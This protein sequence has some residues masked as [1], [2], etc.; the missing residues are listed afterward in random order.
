VE[1]PRSGEEIGGR[2]F[3]NFSF[4]KLISVANV[5]VWQWQTMEN[6]AKID[7]KTGTDNQRVSE[8]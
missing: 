1:F 3:T 6:M 8:R 2:K 5:R 7:Q 4:S